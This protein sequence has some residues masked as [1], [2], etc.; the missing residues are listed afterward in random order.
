MVILWRWFWTSIFFTKI[1]NNSLKRIVPTQKTS[2]CFSTTNSDYTKL[3]LGIFDEIFKMR[4][5]P[6]MDKKN[7]FLLNPNARLFT[8]LAKSNPDWWTMLVRDDDLYID[9]RKNNYLNVYYYGGSVIK[10]QFKNDFI[11]ETHQKY[12]GHY[13]PRGKTKNGNDKFGYDRIDLNTFNREKLIS[14]KEK[15]K[16]DYLKMIDGE[17]PAEKWIQGGLIMGNPC[18]LDSEFQFNSDSQIGNLRIDLIQL[19]DGKLTFIELKKI[20]DSRLR[21]DEKRNT[22][23]PEIIKQMR[24]YQL[25]VTKYEKD[26][27]DYYKKLIS[28]KNMLGLKVTSNTQ[29][30]VNPNPKLI[31]ANTYNHTSARR[32]ERILY[33]EKLLNDNSIDYTITRV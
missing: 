18:Y 1:S 22:T 7:P 9:I 31:I 10:L 15:I 17:N 14:I 29:I 20:T 27:I 32:A 23:A 5:N 28:I 19:K 4:T 21:N 3:L 26:I 12:L 8:E 30:K 11:A 16:T 13:K 33:I 24:K 25:F 6:A 2:P